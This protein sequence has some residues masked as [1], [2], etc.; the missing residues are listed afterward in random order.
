M[1]MRTDST[2]KRGVEWIHYQIS[3]FIIC[4][5]NFCSH[6]SNTTARHLGTDEDDGSWFAHFRH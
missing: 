6:S 5:I 4:Q 1:K 2:I 3:F